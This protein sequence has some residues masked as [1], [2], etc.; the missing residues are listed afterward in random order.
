MVAALR[1]DV[2]VLGDLLLVDHVLAAF[3]AGPQARRDAGLLRWFFDGF[4]LGHG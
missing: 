1:A 4:I 3:A 2:E